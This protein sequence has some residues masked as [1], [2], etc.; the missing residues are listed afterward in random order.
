MEGLE[1][2]RIYQY[3][4]IRNLRERVKSQ[5][6]ALMADRTNQQ[7]LVF[8]GVTKGDLAEIDS[9][10]ASIGKHVRMSHY[11]DSSLLIIKLM[12]SGKHEMSHLTLHL[13]ISHKFIRMGLPDDTLTPVGAT[14]FTRPLSSKEGDSG[15]NP[16]P[17]G[18]KLTGQRLFSSLDSLRHF[19]N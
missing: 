15:Y 5:S 1:G 2:S 4:G 18:M 7:Y 16:F 13:K 14:R 10:R 17:G 9:K 6:T 8:R 11:T 3:K 12:P 19:L